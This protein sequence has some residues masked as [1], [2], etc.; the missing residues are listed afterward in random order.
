LPETLAC[1]PYRLGKQTRKFTKKAI[2][3]GLNKVLKSYKDGR[4][5]VEKM[6]FKDD[7]LL[8]RL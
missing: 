1:Q 7:E 4:D 3:S 6:G 5:K 2:N 8:E